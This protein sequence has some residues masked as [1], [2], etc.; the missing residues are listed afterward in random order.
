MRAIILG[1]ACIGLTA[2]LN[3]NELIEECR[4]GGGLCARDAGAGNGEDAGEGDAGTRDAGV[5]DAGGVDSGIVDAGPADAG[6]ADAGLSDAGLSDAGPPDAG[7]ADAGTDAGAED[8]GFDAGDP[9]VG[10]WVLQGLMVME[11]N[12]AGTLVGFPMDVVRGIGNSYLFK[13]MTPG[14][15]G[16]LCT[17]TFLL[18]AGALQP[19]QTPVAGT[20]CAVPSTPVYLA[21]PPNMLSPPPVMIGLG[22][23]TILTSAGTISDAGLLLMRGTGRAEGYNFRFD[24]TGTR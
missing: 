17:L 7:A 14:A 23:L 5:A 1:A 16:G 8:A 12:D 21:A 2:C 9:F 6:P 19:P 22:S 13:T 4:D 3:F 20:Y 11:V 24:Y 18:T 10:N 15:D